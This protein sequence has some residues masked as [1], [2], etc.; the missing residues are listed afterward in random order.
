MELKFK[1]NATN[2]DE[3]EQSRKLPIENCAT[4]TSVSS[5]VLFMQKGLIDENGKVG[6]SRS[7]AL[8][9]IDKYLAEHDKT[10]LLMDIMEGLV[11]AGFLSKELDV[12]KIRQVKM[13][14]EAQIT[15]ELENNL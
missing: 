8:D 7:V 6:V 3:I 5:M 15:K 13:K 1:F 14:R 9:T 12:E 2:V 4:D 10:E 11:E